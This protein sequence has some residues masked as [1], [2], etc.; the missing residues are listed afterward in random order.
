MAEDRAGKEEV[1]RIEETPGDRAGKEEV[2]RIEETPGDRAGKEEVGRIEETPEV[3]AWKE[4]SFLRSVIWPVQRGAGWR[5][6]PKTAGEAPGFR[7]R[8][9][10]FLPPVREESCGSHPGEMLF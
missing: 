8:R 1:G 5:C 9:P 3:R 4:E 10:G 6:C 2:G 7:L